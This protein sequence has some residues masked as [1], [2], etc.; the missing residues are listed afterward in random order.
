MTLKRGSK[1][2]GFALELVQ[3]E[4]ENSPYQIDRK[5]AQG[6]AFVIFA[7]ISCPTCQWCLPLLDRLHRRYRQTGASV[8]LVLQDPTEEAQEFAAEYGLTMPILID[9][10]P[11]KVSEDYGIEYVPTSFWINSE[12]VIDEVIEAF[13]REAFNKINRKLAVAAGLEPRPLFEPDA[14]IPAFRPG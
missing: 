11:H 8:V 14:G 12:G 13:E 3:P 4:G 5:L 2:P 6:P 1:A 9:P 10:E 7:K